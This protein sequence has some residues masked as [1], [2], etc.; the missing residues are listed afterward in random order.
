MIGVD[1]LKT[2]LLTLPET[3]GVYR[4]LSK[5][6]KALYV[7]KAKNLKKR[8]SSY[9]QVGRLNARL[10]KM[11]SQVA[12]L[13]I[14]ESSSEAEAFLIENDLIKTLHPIYNI[15]LKDDKSFPFIAFSKGEFPRIFK[16]RGALSDD[17]LFGPFSDI[18]A[19]HETLTFLEKIF[20]LRTCA[21]SVF[22]NRQRPCILYQIK[23]C[24]APCCAKIS[25]EDYAALVLDAKNFLKGKSETLQQSLIQYMNEAS[26]RQDYLKAAVFRDR[27]RALNAILHQTFSDLKTL[28]DTDVFGIHEE[29]GSAAIYASF[30]RFGRHA[31][32][33]SFFFDSVLPPDEILSSFIGQFYQTRPL[34]AEILTS[35]PVSDVISDVFHIPVRFSVRGARKMLIEQAVKNAETALRRHLAETEKETRGLL[36]LSELL[37]TDIKLI[38]AYDNS[39]LFG[40][41]PVGICIQA[42]PEGF[43]K[44]GYR[45]FNITSEAGAKGDDPRMMRE[46]LSRR[47]KYEPLPD[48]FLMDGGRGQ[49]SQLVDLLPPEAILIG[50]AKGE[51]RNDGKE[52][53][54]RLLADGSY[55]VLD[56]PEN[57]V[58]RFYLQRLRDE[59]HRFAVGSHRM[60]RK[61]GMFTSELDS[62]PGIGPKKKAALL[63]HFGSVRAIKSATMLELQKVP[64]ISPA[65][66]KKILEGV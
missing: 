10:L 15:L 4:M 13:E 47:M 31:G 28:P 30:I 43:N 3:P 25:K 39:H 2:A 26:G 34:P 62:L 63:H 48:V 32:T 21:D 46:V 8:V 49:L 16:K 36:L 37:G 44:K 64:G 55:Q 24:S 5:D 19:L 1:V 22:S 7:G 54:Y 33:A 23:R 61:K 52:T 58:L 12:K 29:N 51:K 40:T 60:K 45:R 56:I 42:T 14:I 35:L 18:G 50:I 20:L 59:S 57:S 17:T 11:V 66:A 53:F 65:L 27:L 41:H 6:G 38:E 9:T